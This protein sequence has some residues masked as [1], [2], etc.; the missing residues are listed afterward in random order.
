MSPRL[1]GRAG[2]LIAEQGAKAG[3]LARPKVL[4]TLTFVVEHIAGRA[5][6]HMPFLMRHGNIVAI[7]AVVSKRFRDVAA[8]L[9]VLSWEDNHD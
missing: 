6:R 9:S 1:C 3:T 5:R 4:F 8:L 7:L 2:S